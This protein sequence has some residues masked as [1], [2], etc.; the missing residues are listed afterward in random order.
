MDNH[1]PKVVFKTTDT[2]ADQIR[3][4]LLVAAY[5]WAQRT[6]WFQALAQQVKIKMKT[7]TYTPLQKLQTLWASLLVGC[8]HTVEINEKLGADQPAAA[9][10]FGLE[11]FPDQSQVNILLRR[12]TE[13]NVQQLRE[14]HFQTLIENTRGKDR[15]HW[16]R[17]AN[18]QRLLVI[19]LDQMG[20]TVSGKQFERAQPGHFGRKRGRRGYKQSA[21]FLGGTVQEVLDQYLDAGDEHAKRRFADL[22]AGITRYITAL[23]WR[24]AQVLIRGD[25]QYG[26]V[27]NVAHLDR[28]GY[29]YLFKGYHTGRA[30][31]L[32][33]QVPP[34]TIYYRVADDAERH[35]RWVADAGVHTLVEKY[36]SDPAAAEKAEARVRVFILAHTKEQTVR[37]SRYKGSRKDHPVRREVVLAHRLT[38]LTRQQVDEALALTLYDGRA[39]SEN[40]FKDEQYG[41]LM[42]SLRTR[43]FAG[44]AGGFW[45]AVMVFNQLTW[46]RQTTLAG[47]ELAKLGVRKLIHSVMQV[48]ARVVRTAQK[49]T[50]YLPEHNYIARLLLKGRRRRPPRTTAAVVLAVTRG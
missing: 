11:R 39:T 38:N 41:R 26:T 34:Q 49:I 27:A 9:A 16:V 20:L 42:K 32:A 5:E 31:K 3:S 47:T 24:P 46:L 45:L 8:Q 6:G 13:E 14:V 28:L 7:V 22:V 21:V 30:Q 10:L 29:K 18:R 19:D 25:A 17:L 15:Q 1:T 4:G 35:P 40:Y 37:S 2:F 43:A 44:I 12:L 48:P 33:A 36:P 23:G 50:V